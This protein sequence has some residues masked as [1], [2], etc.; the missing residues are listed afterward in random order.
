MKNKVV[1]VAIA[2]D[3]GEYIAEW[4]EF[5]LLQGISHFYINIAGSS[6]NTEEILK[7][8]PGIVTLV[9]Y[10]IIGEDEHKIH[11]WQLK[12]Y[13]YGVIVSK[14]KSDW[15]AI[16]D[17]DE[18][19][20]ARNSTLPIALEAYQGQNIGCIAI[21]WLMFGSAGELEKKPG[22]V[23]ERFTKRG[24][25]PHVH[26]KSLFKSNKYVEQGGNCHTVRVRGNI[27]DE[28]KKILPVEYAVDW[29]LGY[30]NI[31]AI[32]HYNTKSKGEC[33]KRWALRDGKA[34]EVKN[35]EE[36]FKANDLNEV[37]D[38]YVQKYKDAIKGNLKAL[39]V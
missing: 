17:I 1:I 29:S 23:I 14:T 5:H 8:Y 11:L 37:E 12:A 16:L 39:T 35:K 21:R 15:I 20:Y 13:H 34:T 10:P 27:V 24:K 30:A 7:R 18:F 25:D 6:D 26:C 33:F 2:K 9:D 32:N 28:N 19:L 22:L 3:E 31:L 4:I 36:L 38:L